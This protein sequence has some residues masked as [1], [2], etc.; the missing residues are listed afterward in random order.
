[1]EQYLAYLPQAEGFLPKW[2]FFVSSAM[3]SLFQSHYHCHSE[4]LAANASLTQSKLT[5][6][7]ST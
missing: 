6:H 2:L 4:P 5:I 3:S 1:M 7:L